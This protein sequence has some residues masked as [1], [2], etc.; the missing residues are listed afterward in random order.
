[1]TIVDLSFP[2]AP[3][4]VPRDHGY[5]LYGALSRA[6]PAL[7]EARWLGVHPLSGQ[8]AAGETL[9]TSLRS[10]LR[11]R[12]PSEKIAETLPLAGK[13]LEVRGVRLTLG[14]PSVHPII[15]AASLDARLVLVKL[16]SVPK[17]EHA[18]LGRQTLDLAKMAPRVEAELGKQLDR[19]GVRAR[20]ELRGHGR[21]TVGG[22][23]VIGFSVRVSGLNADESICLQAEGLGGKRRMGCGIFRPT[24]A[25]RRVH[26]ENRP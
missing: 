20:A 22:R 24:R 8:L 7:H 14:A 2:F 25:P 16:T 5:A 21:I 10:G 12:L 1:V 23:S 6:A 11:L 3:V 13:T 17:H 18:E 26:V 19:L 4:D 9:R 15:P